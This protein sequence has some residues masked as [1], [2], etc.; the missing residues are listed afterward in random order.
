MG[1]KFLYMQFFLK[2]FKCYFRFRLRRKRKIAEFQEI[3]FTEM[4]RRID[5]NKHPKR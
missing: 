5:T 3:Y 4:Q 1:E 2:I